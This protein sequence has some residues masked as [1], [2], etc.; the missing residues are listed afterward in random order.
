[1]IDLSRFNIGDTVEGTFRFTITQKSSMEWGADC[2]S[3]VSSNGIF[4]SALLDSDIFSMEVVQPD[5][6]DDG[7]TTEEI[8]KLA[9]RV[10]ALEDAIRSNSGLGPRLG[11]GGYGSVNLLQEEEYGIYND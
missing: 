5:L 6:C 2:N 1:M 7:W 8:N 11:H 4:S 10:R 9:K 3:I